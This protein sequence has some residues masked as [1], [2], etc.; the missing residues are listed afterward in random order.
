MCMCLVMSL[1][2]RE[3]ICKRFGKK[4]HHI[5]QSTVNFGPFSGAGSAFPPTHNFR[6][7]YIMKFITLWHVNGIMDLRARV[8]AR[9]RSHDP[10]DVARAIY[11]ALSG[12]REW[13][14]RLLTD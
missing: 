3:V 2:L 11:T 10:T 1:K 4:S 12:S 7:V 6:A 5:S 8:T 9:K 14:R 13:G